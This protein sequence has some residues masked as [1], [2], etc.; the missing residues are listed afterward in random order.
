MVLLEEILRRQAM[1]R[2][3]ERISSNSLSE[4]AVVVTE[5]QYD[6]FP[7]LVE[8]LA[9]LNC[10]SYRDFTVVLV[11]DSQDPRLKTLIDLIIKHKRLPTVRYF[12]G[13][14]MRKQKMYYGLVFDEYPQPL[15]FDLLYVV[16]NVKK[17]ASGSCNV[18][19][20][21]A[22][23]LCK[24][25]YIALQDADDMSIYTRLEEQINFLK[26]SDCVGVSSDKLAFGKSWSGHEGYTSRFLDIQYSPISKNYEG[27]TN[28]GVIRAQALFFASSMLKPCMTFKTEMLKDLPGGTLFDDQY[29][30]FGDDIIMNA[31]LGVAGNLGVVQKP[32]IMYRTHDSNLSKL[33]SQVHKPLYEKAI[34]QNLKHICNYDASDE[35]LHNYAMYYHYRQRDKGFK[36]FVESTKEVF[37][38]NPF[39]T[40]QHTDFLV[41]S[42]ILD[43]ETRKSNSALPNPFGEAVGE[44]KVHNV[45]PNK[46]VKP[47]K[48]TKGNIYKWL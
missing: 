8:C 45:N 26:N 48:P 47:T 46:T 44:R 24:P 31:R 23:E 30:H 16:N 39:V 17:G 32:L 37:A 5:H 14:K 18:G 6:R 15:T 10:Q 36:E 43:H 4:T 12:E 9:A 20:K 19:I 42:I 25:K 21:A 11:D 2:R 41:D 33:G 7:Y 22:L 3:M 35:F 29:E 40:R 28:E 34:K 38:L 27:L 1:A 13:E